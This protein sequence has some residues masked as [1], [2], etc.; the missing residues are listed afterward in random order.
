MLALDDRGSSLRA[1][2]PSAPAA[3]TAAPPRAEQARELIAQARDP[4]TGQVDTKRLAGWVADAS[5]QDF[6]KASAAHAAIENELVAQGRTGDLSRFNEDVVAAAQRV[7]DI[8]P[9]GLTGAGQGMIQ[10]GGKLLVDNPILTKVWE[11]T[12]SAWTGK[13]GFTSNLQT[14]LEGHGIEIAPHVNAAPPGS[15]GK[16]SGVASAVANNTNGALARDA[17]A[18][19]WRNA[20]PSY[21]V[22]IEQPRSN[23]ARIVDVVVDKPAADP[24]MN[25]R[26]E[27]ESKVGRK[28]LGSEV[29]GQAAYD[30]A[31][32]RENRSLRGAGRVLEGVGKVARPVGIALDAIEIGS[33]FKADGNKVGANTGRAVSGVAGGALG[34]WGGAVG[35]AA[36]GTMIL[37]GVGTVVGGLIGGAI[38]AFAGD[39]AGKGLFDTVK[40]WF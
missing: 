28:G 3:S 36:I 33:A 29:R 10:A 39:Q 11:G 8:A 5:G 34:G 13:G 23:G 20:D 22:S 16:G 7:A 27:I 35:G 32:L 38:G 15:L 24:R 21:R 14:L 40:G 18:D 9:N 31:A 26:I 30:G 37:P 12:T 17:I 19:R 2:P 25:E 1:V 6:A 4:A